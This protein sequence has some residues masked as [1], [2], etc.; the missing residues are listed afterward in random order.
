MD[1]TCADIDPNCQSCGFDPIT[2]IREC[3]AC[4]DNR[5][6]ENG[7]CKCKVGFYE[8]GDGTCAK[9]GEGCALCQVIDND[10]KCFECALNAQ[11]QNDDGTCTCPPSTIIA[12]GA[13]TLFCKACSNKCNDC[14]NT[15]DFCTSCN[16]PATLMPST[17]ECMCPDGTYSSSSGECTQCMMSCESC[18]SATN[19]DKCAPL[20]VFDG[21]K[22]TLNCPRGTFKDGSECKACAEG[23]DD[24]MNGFTCIACQSGFK[25][26]LGGCLAACPAG[27]FALGGGDTC[28]ACVSPCKTCSGPSNSECD[29]CVDGFVYFNR[30]CRTDCIEGTYFADGSCLACSNRCKT[31]TGIS[32]QCTS[33]FDRQFLY[34]G[35]CFN[36]CPAAIVNDIC[37]DK[38]PD[39]NYLDGN[40]CRPCSN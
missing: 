8:K 12:E 14:M 33:C 34:K 36:E 39:G 27:T 24:C 28:F 7:K 20:H 22:C 15:F 5:I 10:L 26:Y 29:S 1:A 17:G 16:P 25:I 21:T 11:V 18:T 40:V 32:T 35:N 23:C 9:C 3:L 19:C 4:A 2:G 13:G 31:C 6:V 37:T 30:E 38:C